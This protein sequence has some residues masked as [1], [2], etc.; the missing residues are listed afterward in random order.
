MNALLGATVR[1]KFTEIV[2]E[3]R[4]YN[5]VVVTR[6]D[7]LYTSIESRSDEYGSPV[8]GRQL[9]THLSQ[10]KMCCVQE[11]DMYEEK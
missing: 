4:V 11:Y 7:G 5:Q 8:T 1:K 6:S 10:Y 9:S 3:S 2:D